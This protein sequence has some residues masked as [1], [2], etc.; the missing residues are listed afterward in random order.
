MLRV[1][2]KPRWIA[3]LIITLVISGTC[4][5]LGVW[6]MHRLRDV[7]AFNDSV[8]AGLSRPPTPLDELIPASMP[9]SDV[10]AMRYRLVVAA[11]HYDTSHEVVLYGRTLN[12][13]PGN[14]VLTPLVLPDGRAVI[15]DRGWVPFEMSKAPVEAAAPP[16]GTVEVTGVLEPAEPPGSGPK[17]GP[18]SLVTTVDL[19]RLTLQMPY[20]LLPMYLRLQSQVPA[21]SGALPVPTPLPPLTEGPYQGYMLQWFV[22]ATIFLGGYWVL[23]RREA[24]DRRPAHTEA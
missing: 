8:T 2:A 22:F 11:G 7:R 14:H 21:Q 4:V 17:S 23:V 5:R 24:R 12:E 1:L 9:S 10:E 13:T 15:V 18:I 20:P 16:S 6:Q 19:P 3:L